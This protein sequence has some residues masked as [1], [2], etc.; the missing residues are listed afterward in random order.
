MGL[1][2]RVFLTPPG[3]FAL[4]PPR[5]LLFLLLSKSRPSSTAK[6]SLDRLLRPTADTGDG[7]PLLQ[8][9]AL[10]VPRV[11]GE[12]G[13]A[14]CEDVPAVDDSTGVEAGF[15]TSG[16]SLV[17][18][19]S[20]RSSVKKIPWLAKALNSASTSSADW[21]GRRGAEHE[22]HVDGKDNKVVDF[23]LQYCN[24]VLHLFSS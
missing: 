20:V 5:R 9:P 15:C 22:A 7:G 6:S 21:V 16:V 17:K 14:A 11:E 1:L 12:G 13:P 10:L 4:L 18:C 3:A 24:S 2:K 23:D 19:T 8:V